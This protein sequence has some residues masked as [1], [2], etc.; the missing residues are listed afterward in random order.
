MFYK[1]DDIEKILEAGIGNGNATPT[2][3]D[4]LAA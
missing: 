3:A 1:Y 2:G 4:S